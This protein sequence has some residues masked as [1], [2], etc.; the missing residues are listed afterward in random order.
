MLGLKLTKWMFT[1]NINGLAV[2]NAEIVRLD[3]TSRPNCVIQKNPI[4]NILKEVITL[5]EDYLIYLSSK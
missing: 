4:T 5:S 1:L 2:Q 3:E